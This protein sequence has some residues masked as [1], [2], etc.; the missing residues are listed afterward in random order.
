MLRHYSPSVQQFAERILG[1][2]L[3]ILLVILPKAHPHI[4]KNF[5]FYFDKNR[6]LTDLGFLCYT[7]K[8]KHE[9]KKAKHEPKNQ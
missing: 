9:N 8:P 3:S 6:Q 1:I 7:L 4:N 2:S 5:L